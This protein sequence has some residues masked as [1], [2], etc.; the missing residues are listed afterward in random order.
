MYVFQFLLYIL[1]ALSVSLRLFLH[2][3]L[4][5]LTPP[6]FLSL[7]EWNFSLMGE[8]ENEQE[9]EKLA[10]ENENGNRSNRII[11]FF[12]RRQFGG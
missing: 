9:K 8:N 6:Q 11:K 3:L 10:H 5:L 7:R 2:P 4:T 12:A 1:Y